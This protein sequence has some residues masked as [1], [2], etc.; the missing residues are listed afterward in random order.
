MAGNEFSDLESEQTKER[1][2]MKSVVDSVMNGMHVTSVVSIV[3]VVYCLSATG[4]AFAQQLVDGEFSLTDDQDGSDQPDPSGEH[5]GLSEREVADQSSLILT[6]QVLEQLEVVR[7]NVQAGQETIERTARENRETA[8]RASLDSG[9]YVTFGLASGLRISPRPGVASAAIDTQTV[10]G[11]NGD[12]TRRTVRVDDASV[13]DFSAAFVL[14]VY[15]WPYRAD[16]G[17]RLKSPWRGLSR[18]G[19]AASISLISFSSST[20]SI[21]GN[22]EGGLGV[23]VRLIDQF[24]FAVMADYSRVRVPRSGVADMGDVGFREPTG[25]VVGSTSVSDDR[26]FRTIGSFALAFRFVWAFSDLGRPA[27]S[28]AVK[29]SGT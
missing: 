23:S 19:V 25:E 13:A 27:P 20:E 28:D 21:V 22:I 17:M 15:P 1:T 11:E 26:F 3:S 9:R 16:P 7:Q 8:E 24:H 2:S 10:V 29:P 4:V 5:G 12:V 18:L 14:L 6:A